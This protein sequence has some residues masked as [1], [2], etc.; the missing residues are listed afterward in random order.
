MAGKEPAGGTQVV[1]SANT[2]RRQSIIDDLKRRI[3]LGEISLGER[4]IE[5]DVTR[6]LGTSRPTVREA[7]NQLAR[8]G[9]LVQEAYRG[10]RVSEVSVERVRE[11]AAVRLVNDMAAIDAILAD[12]T[13]KR[14][15][16]LDATL[17]TYLEQM[18]DPD[19]L[20]RHEAH[21]AFHRGVW[22][23]SGN[24]FMMKFWPVMEAEMTL[25][26]AATQHHRHDDALLC[27]H[28]ELLVECIRRGDRAEIR[29]TLRAHV[30]GAPR[31]LH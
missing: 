19:S 31:T 9:Y 24:S 4:I 25:V 16:V 17:A 14:M 29:E 28:H 10:Y 1:A 12:A 7:L 30:E 20:G 6:R 21:M 26:L 5:A 2:Q 18:R 27:T 3:V 8:H 11:L 23:A 22:E 13:G 15:A